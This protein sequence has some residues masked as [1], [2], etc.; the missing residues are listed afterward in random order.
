MLFLWLLTR[1]SQGHLDLAHVFESDTGRALLSFLLGLAFATLFFVN[2]HG[3]EC[4]QFK[5]PVYDQLQ[6][7]IYRTG[8]STCMRTQ[9][10]PAACDAHK[11]ILP[12]AD[13]VDDAAEAKRAAM[14]TFLKKE[15]GVAGTQVPPGASGRPAGL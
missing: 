14:P 8:A 9:L 12:F 2:C 13:P 1:S 11:K 3:V 15:D 5:G 7:A 10:V 4:V 6:G